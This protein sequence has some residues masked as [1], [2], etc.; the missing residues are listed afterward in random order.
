MT[1]R[2]GAT[3]SPSMLSGGL[4]LTAHAQNYSEPPPEYKRCMPCPLTPFNWVK[5]HLMSA[6]LCEE[7][8][9]LELDI[10]ASKLGWMPSAMHLSFYLT[11]TYA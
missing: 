10:W 8:P 2:G 7:E 6:G 3:V 4:I 9:Q 1:A 5:L 11:H